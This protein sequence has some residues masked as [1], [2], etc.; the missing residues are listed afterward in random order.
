MKKSSNLNQDVVKELEKKNPFIKKAISELKKISRSPEFRKL[1]EA[2]KKEEMEY[3]A[4]Q[5]EIRNAYQEGLEKGKEKGLE[6][7]YLG[8]QLNLESRFHIQKDDSL[9]K[10]IR[11]IKD[12]DKLKKILIQSV[13]A[14]N[15]TDFKKL[16]KSK[17]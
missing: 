3:D 10:E 6:G 15:I 14:K 16:L 2:R 1:Y 9:I 4:Y 13:K 7:I 8:I 11:K 12:I 5:T 17:K